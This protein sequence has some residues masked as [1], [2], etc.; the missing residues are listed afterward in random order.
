MSGEPRRPR[1]AALTYDRERDRAPRVAAAGQ[2]KIAERI[3]ELAREHGVPLREDPDLVGIL[4]ALDIDA[5]I[6]P[7]LYV[8]IAEVLAWAY[9]TNAEYGAAGG[10][11]RRD[12]VRE[13]PSSASPP[14][15]SP[16]GPPRS[17]AG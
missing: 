6:P 8:V 1:A 5:E 2:G 14:P 9:R 7:E 10:R 17:P 16:G 12:T 4:S 11:G 3:L 15:T 13:W